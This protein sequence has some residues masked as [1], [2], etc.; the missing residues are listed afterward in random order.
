MV[1]KYRQDFHKLLEE[2]YREL[3]D[4]AR[5]VARDFAHLDTE[6]LKHIDFHLID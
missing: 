5:K 2:G 4:E 6:S 3:A 1:E